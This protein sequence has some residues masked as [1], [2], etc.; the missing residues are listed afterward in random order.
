MYPNKPVRAAYIESNV[1]Q[2][3]RIIVPYEDSWHAIFWFKL[4]K[5]GSIYFGPSY[6]PT[7]ESS[8]GR[9]IK[10]GTSYSINPEDLVEITDPVLINDSHTSVHPSGAINMSGQ[11]FY[12]EH[13]KNL[14][15]QEHICS[16]LFE[17]PENYPEVAA[18]PGRPGDVYLKY[19]IDDSRPLSGEIDVAPRGKERYILAKNAPYQVNLIFRFSGFKD[20]VDRSVQFVL[21]HLNES[22][23]PNATYLI[24][25]AGKRVWRDRLR[26]YWIRLTSPQIV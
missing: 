20:N 1:G 8:I 25:P 18:P 17:R 14:F 9:K 10:P 16:I 21:C 13:L 3:I 12:R 5:D 22:T 2:G 11:R 23:W 7:G 19:P 24:L 26:R 4:G 6:K 15:E